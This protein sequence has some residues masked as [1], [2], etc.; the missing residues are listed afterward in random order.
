MPEL[1]ASTTAACLWLD[2]HSY[3]SQLLAN[4]A[5]PVLEVADYVAFRR[6]A[7]ALLASD[8]VQFSLTTVCHAWLNEHPDLVATMAA[9]ARAVAPLRAMLSD[10]SL[11]AHLVATVTALRRAFV[12]RPLVILLPSPR[13]WVGITCAQAGLEEIAVGQAEAD[14]AAVYVAEFLRAFAECELDGILLAE[15]ENDQPATADEVTWYQPVFNVASHFRWKAGLLLPGEALPIDLPDDVDF[16]VA[17]S[18]HGVAQT[19]LI[20]PASVW[21]DESVVASKVGE[22]TYAEI[23]HDAPP[24]RVLAVID[25]LRDGHA[26]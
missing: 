15:Q 11:R 1:L 22:L 5:A 10:E 20:Q 4:N 2:D 6:Q 18:A 13:A 12:T 3:A 25:N 16:V 7:A 19:C 8:V 21:T 24:E 9:K 14:K 17:R 26:K 23:P